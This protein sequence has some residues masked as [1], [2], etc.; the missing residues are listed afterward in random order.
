MLGLYFTATP[1]RPKAW[2]NEAPR[3]MILA[4]QGGQIEWPSNTMLAF[5]EAHKTGSDVLDCDL[6]MTADK[7]LVILHDTTVD[8]TTNGQ[9][10]V[11]EMTWAEV[12]KLD[13]AYRFTRDGKTFPLRGKGIRIPRL[14]EVLKTFPD[15]R[16]QMEVKEASPAIAQELAKV[17]K[18]LEAEDRVLLS[19]F[20]DILM[21]ELRM[22]C[23]QVATSASPVEIRALV[24][25]S[26]L[27]LEALISPAYSALQ[28]PLQYSGID[29]VTKRTVDAAHN[30][31]VKVLP[32]T[33]DSDDGVEICRQAGADGFNT[34]LPTKM[35]RVRQNW[36]HLQAPLFSDD[37]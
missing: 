5:S 30:R 20:D 27:H 19:C 3:P 11:A 13:A 23:P 28:I 21:S 12:A 26:R 31:G 32:W 33:I 35:E 18:Q 37:R 4:H 14:D 8:R 17:L 24:L 6:H 1:A 25:A 16:I 22:A 10:V 34:N 9:G 36:T 29:L 7:V 15:W 2:F